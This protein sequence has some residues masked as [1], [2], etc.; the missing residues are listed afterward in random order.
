M[1]NS[2]WTLVSRKK[3]DQPKHGSHLSPPK[4]KV[5]GYSMR[6]KRR[7]AHPKLGPKYE[8]QTFACIRCGQ[9]QKRDAATPGQE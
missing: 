8:L 5:C 9:L 4:C 6:I 3:L 7:E 1:A 2:G